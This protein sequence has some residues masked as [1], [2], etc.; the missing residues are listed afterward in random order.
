MAAKKP[1]PKGTWVRKNHGRNH[2]YHRVIDDD[3]GTM[4]VSGV[5]TIISDGLPKPALIGWAA[6]SVADFVA[7]NLSKGK[8]GHYYADEL[9]EAIRELAV[10]AKRPLPEKLSRTAIAK[11]LSGLPNSQRDKA[12]NRGTEVHDIA[13]RLAEGEEV[14]VPE[15]LK[16]HVQ[17][18]MDFRADWDPYDEI[19]ELPVFSRKHMYGGT[20]DLGC[21][22]RKAAHL[23]FSLIDIK[24]SRSGPFGE[25]A[26]QLAGYRFA[27]FYVD[28]DGVEVPMPEFD[29]VHVLW[30]RADG[31]DLYPVEADVTEHRAFLYVQQVAMFQARSRDL[32][33]E[34]LIPPAVAP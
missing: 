12:G 34:A 3:G 22:L 5:T 31:Y 20:L 26:L 28:D 15:E 30:L 33:G 29:S 14:V 19:V 4:K 2:S 23:G 11:A 24:T 21:R 27:D 32:I 18:Y 25:V 7:D 16:G 8:D 13:R 17:S 9:V 1:P 10:E 6:G